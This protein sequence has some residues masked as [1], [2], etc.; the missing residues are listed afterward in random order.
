VS[1]LIHLADATVST[2]LYYEYMGFFY[3]PFRHDREF[4]FTRAYTSS[5]LAHVFDRNDP[6]YGE[7]PKQSN[8]PRDFVFLNRL[9]WGLW[10][11][12][13]EL[14][15]RNHWHRIHREYIEG[16]EPANESAVPREPRPL[17]QKRDARRRRV[18]LSDG[19]RSERG[20]ED[21]PVLRCCL[22]LALSRPPPPGRGR[23][24]WRGRRR[25]QPRATRVA[26]TRRGSRRVIAIVNGGS[27]SSANFDDGDLNYDQGLV[28][29]ALQMSGELAARWSIFGLYVRG[30]SFYDF[31]S[32]LADRERTRL[33]THAQRYVG[34][35]TELR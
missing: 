25:G 26:R 9:Q 3:E 27:S 30:I 1:R 34:S 23:S 12:L 21:E 18:W 6:R 8:M 19:P 16:A 28:S 29:N 17:A 4:T 10:P 32:E 35:D 31:E 20:A 11:L 15:A 33:T 13:A 22:A 5:S 14:G 7:I 2:E 24:S